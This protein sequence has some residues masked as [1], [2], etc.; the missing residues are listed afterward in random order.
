MTTSAPVIID[1]TTIR[2]KATWTGFSISSPPQWIINWF[3]DYNAIS[4]LNYY[5]VSNTNWTSKISTLC[6]T[7]WTAY[8]WV[9]RLHVQKLDQGPKYHGLSSESNH[10]NA[11][12]WVVA[13]NGVLDSESCSIKKGHFEG[14]SGALASGGGCCLKLWFYENHCDI[15]RLWL[16]C[17]INRPVDSHKKIMVWC[18]EKAWDWSDSFGRYWSWVGVTSKQILKLIS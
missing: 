3:S 9:S 10:P 13:I 6:F 7:S 1:S 17:K 8:I 16:L 2:W 5:I 12:V 4:E 18:M 11:V 15:Q 14:E